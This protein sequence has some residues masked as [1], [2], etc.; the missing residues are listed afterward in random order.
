[1]GR[2]C[3][4]CFPLAMQVMSCGSL[5]VP[6]NSRPWAAPPTSL[7]AEA[8]AL[9]ALPAPQRP[10]PLLPAL[11]SG[12]APLSAGASVLGVLALNASLCSQA[13]PSPALPALGCPLLIPGERLEQPSPTPGHTSHIACSLSSVLHSW[14]KSPTPGCSPSALPLSL[15][16]HPKAP[17]PC[18]CGF[19]S[20]GRLPAPRSPLHRLL[21]VLR[22]SFHLP[23]AAWP[24]NL[25]GPSHVS[26]STRAAHGLTVSCCLWGWLPPVSVAGWLRV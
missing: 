16:P 9:P 13:P 17:S 11:L 18:T 19:Q 25:V 15:W 2:S 1:M 21:Q 14:K 4:L 10:R 3:R 24:Q 26:P 20:R 22:A 7:S 5:P 12:G 8:P 23:P 6:V